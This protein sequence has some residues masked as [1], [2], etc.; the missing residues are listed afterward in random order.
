MEPGQQWFTVKEAAEYLR[1]SLRKFT[2]LGIQAHG[3]GARK[4]YHRPILDA[5]MLARPWQTSGSFTRDTDFIAQGS[6]RYGDLADRLAN[7]RK[8]PYK[9]RPRKKRANASV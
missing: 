3:H 5:A 2:D 9:P 7:V 4:V 8:R 1:Q 6:A